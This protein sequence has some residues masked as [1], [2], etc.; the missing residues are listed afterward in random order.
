MNGCGRTPLTIGCPEPGGEIAALT[1]FWRDGG[2]SELVVFNIVQDGIIVTSTRAEVKTCDHGDGTGA[3]SQTIEDFTG[4]IDGCTIT[5]QITVCRFGVTDMSGP[6]GVV[7][8][9]FTVRL[10]PAHDRIEGELTDPVTG[11]TLVL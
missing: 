11:D 2:K 5:G 8:L 4:F 6:N 7:K 3:T 9:E 10:N 1:D